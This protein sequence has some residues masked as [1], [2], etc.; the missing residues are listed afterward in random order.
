V[1]VEVL[2]NGSGRTFRTRFEVQ[3]YLPYPFS[4]PHVLHAVVHDFEFE[5]RLVNWLNRFDAACVCGD[6]LTTLG[7]N[8]VGTVEITNA[9]LRIDIH[10]GGRTTL[11][12]FVL[13][14]VQLLDR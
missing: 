13:G 14:R 4:H 5:S 6:A 1:S 12:R 11:P 3:H 8:C 7:D 2:L 10:V 9:V